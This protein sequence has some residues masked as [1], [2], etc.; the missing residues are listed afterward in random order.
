MLHKSLAAAS[1][2]GCPMPCS[3]MTIDIVHADEKIFKQREAQV[4]VSNVKK[5]TV[6]VRLKSLP[7]IVVSEQ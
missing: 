2:A 1:I 7:Y 5:V 3:C 4:S 6:R